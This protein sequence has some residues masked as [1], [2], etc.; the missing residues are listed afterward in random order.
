MEVLI[1]AF[2][3]I[4]NYQVIFAV[5]LAG[6]FGLFMGAMPGLTSSMTLAL[7]VPITFFLDPIPALA[8]MASAATM[9]IFAGDIPGALLKIPGTPASAAYCEDANMLTKQGKAFHALGL[10]LIASVIGGFI[11]VVILFLGA[12]ILAR[13]ALNFSSYEYFWLACLGLSCATLVSSEQPQKGF[14]S[15]LLGLL[16]ATIGLDQTTGYARFTFGNVDLMGG[17]SFIPMMIGMFALAEVLNTLTQK[18]K[19]DS[20]K[21]AQIKTASIGTLLHKTWNMKSGVTRSSLIGTLTGA[22]PGAGADIASWVS[23]ALSKKLSKQP[24]LYGKGSEEGISSASAANNASIAGGWIPSL[25]FGIPGDSGAA[26]IIGVLY[27]KDLAPGP[28]LFLYNPEILYATFGIF[29]L[30]NLFLFFAGFKLIKLSSYILRVPYSVLAPLIILF[31]VLG[32]FSINNSWFGVI[33]MCVSGLVGWLMIQAKMPVAP[34]I[35]G[36][37]LGP[38][39]EKNLLT[40]IVKS[41]GNIISFFERPVAGTIGG[42]TIVIWALIIVSFIRKSFQKREVE[43]QTNFE[44]N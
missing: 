23:Y 8:V 31:C 43:E 15:L 39:L 1:H 29:L 13:F 20:N 14:A 9:A 35:L 21:V 37:V 5:V 4:S 7:L 28:T 10:G 24:E 34:A 12:P 42:I 16:V 30:A 33:V 26:I 40:S 17:I 2:T 27:L 11:S 22:I 38:L 36:M 6:S 19:K 18:E 44:A 41:Q 25:V 32:S 3:L